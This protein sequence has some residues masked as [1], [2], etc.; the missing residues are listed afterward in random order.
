MPDAGKKGSDPFD[1]KDDG[2]SLMAIYFLI[3][4]TG[5]HTS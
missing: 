3:S 1:T 5:Y 4:V 2:V